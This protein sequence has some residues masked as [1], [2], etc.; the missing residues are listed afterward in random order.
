[1][2]VD[3][4]SASAKTTPPRVGDSE[5]TTTP[6]SREADAP[7][8]S[9]GAAGT[10]VAVVSP[11]AMAAAL[12]PLAVVVSFFAALSS[13]TSHAAR[14]TRAANSDVRGLAMLCLMAC[15]VVVRGC[16][17]R[18]AQEEGHPRGLPALTS[19]GL[20]RPPDVHA[21]HSPV[22]ERLRLGSAKR[23]RVASFLAAALVLARCS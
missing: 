20:G 14:M 2:S 22:I 8:V 12:A 15:M 7:S 5:S 23:F 1:M 9:E 17:P 16:R 19:A 11:G 6:V 4:P 18:P 21:R 10:P 3:A 13:T